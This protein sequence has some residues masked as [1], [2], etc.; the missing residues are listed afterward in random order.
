MIF[1]S[2]FFNFSNNIERLEKQAEDILELPNNLR[3]FRL[4]NEVFVVD[5][6][7]NKIIQKFK[8]TFPANPARATLEIIKKMKLACNDSQITTKTSNIW[9]CGFRE[10]DARWVWYR[11]SNPKMTVS[12]KEAYAQENLQDKLYFFSARFGTSI[13]N[14]IK[15]EGI[16]KI[17]KKI[18]ASIL[19]NS[20]VLIKCSHCNLDE[21]YTIDDIVDEKKNAKY[22]SNF[23]VCLNCNN[24]INL[25]NE[26]K[27]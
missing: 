3:A 19:E 6:A 13:I 7:K 16:E 25:I 15:T 22:D 20:F 5:T 23:V 8:N 24:L 26:S 11:N 12:F 18:N 10:N 17:S 14:D 9:T 1:I 2:N 27:L 4:K 21:I